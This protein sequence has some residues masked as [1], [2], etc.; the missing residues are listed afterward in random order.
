ML[1]SQISLDK[2][3]QL[4]LMRMAVKIN[5]IDNKHLNKLIYSKK[6]KLNHGIMVNLMINNQKYLEK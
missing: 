3:D 1:L 5:N 4:S 6:I 2:F